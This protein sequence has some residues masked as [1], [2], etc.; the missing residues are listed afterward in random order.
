MSLRPVFFA[1]VAAALLSGCAD[2]QREDIAAKAKLRM[3]GLS[4]NSI[5]SCLGEPKTKSQE[6]GAE[7]WS[8]Y[9]SSGQAPR[10]ETFYGLGGFSLPSNS[11]VKNYC[12]VNVTMKKGVAQAVEYL[13]PSSSN[14]YNKDD[15]CG[16]LVA[17]CLKK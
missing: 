3:I 14:F 17:P 6:N 13:G 7:I 10:E 12:I 16:Y 11:Y 2:M 9:S 1:I 4:K 8:Y 15:L 5:Q